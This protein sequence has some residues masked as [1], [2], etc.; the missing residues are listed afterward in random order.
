M[1]QIG[2]ITKPQGI[3]GEFRASIE[4]IPVDALE[5]LTEI[6]IKNII[7]PVKKVTI[8]EAFVIFAVE[9]ITDRNQVELLRNEKIMADVEI[10]LEED[11]VLI[12]DIIGFEV[13]LNDGKVLGKLKDV[14]Y[15]GASEIYVVNGKNEIMF[16]NARGV[17]L[18]FD[19]ANK[20]IVLDAAI[21]E[22]IRIDN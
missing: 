1:E 5:R 9:G 6:K 15:F 21:L 11:E 13:V 20:K 8:K 16:P 2:Y 10:E 22:E 19:M 7:Y 14:E 3:K 4:G 12:K 17:I 18:D